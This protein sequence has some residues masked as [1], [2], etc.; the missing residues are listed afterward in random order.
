MVYYNYLD[1]FSNEVLNLNK[2]ILCLTNDIGLQL[3]DLIGF[4]AFLIEENEEYAYHA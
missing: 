4:S 1:K 3:I 2:S